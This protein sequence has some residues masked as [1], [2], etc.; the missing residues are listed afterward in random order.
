M[1]KK[2]MAVFTAVMM[3]FTLIPAGMSFA[4]AAGGVFILE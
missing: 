1:K 4:E 3:I 2:F